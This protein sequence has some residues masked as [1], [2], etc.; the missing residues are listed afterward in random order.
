MAGDDKQFNEALDEFLN[1]P[2]ADVRTKLLN[3]PKYTDRQHLTKFLA[4]YEIFKRVLGVHG[5]FVECGVFHG[6]GL[7]TWAQLSAI[8]EPSNYGRKVVGFDTFTGLPPESITAHDTAAVGDR[9]SDYAIVGGAYASIGRGEIE[10]AAALFD[11]N[12][13]IG[14]VPKIELVEGDAVG[15]I[16][17]YVEEHPH[18]VV[19]LLNLDFGLYEATKVALERFVPLMPKGAVIVFDDLYN[20]RWPGDTAAVDAA[21]G[22]HNLRIRRFAFEPVV[23]YAVV[24]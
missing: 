2:G 4:R 20:H 7:F 1:G 24:E 15:T 17:R 19:A 21:L 12:R 8:F 13:S 10:Q 18:L 9:R 22:L 16:P 14:H 6:G 23:S 11:R 5:A 3:F